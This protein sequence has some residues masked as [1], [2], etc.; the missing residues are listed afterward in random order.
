MIVRLLLAAVLTLAFGAGVGAQ[1][2]S[3]RANYLLLCSGCHNASGMGSEEGGVPAFPGS[4]GKIAGFDRGRT[5]MMHVPGVV[6]NALTD[7]EIADVMNYVLDTWAVDEGAARFTG[8]EVAARRKLPVPDVVAE[9]RAVA[10][11]LAGKGID[12]ATYPWP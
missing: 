7:A 6:S 4:V 5:Y 1:E 9:R 10:A 8:G 12:L 2:R 11:D 3:A